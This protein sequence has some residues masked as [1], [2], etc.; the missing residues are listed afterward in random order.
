MPY[1]RIEHSTNS[2][3]SSLLRDGSRNA[4]IRPYFGVGGTRHPQQL[5]DFTEENWVKQNLVGVGSAEKQR[6]Y[7]KKC[8]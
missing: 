8:L 4:Q 3:V 7:S 1:G 6:A 5:V 2:R